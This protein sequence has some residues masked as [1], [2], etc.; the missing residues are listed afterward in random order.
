MDPQPGAQVTPWIS[1]VCLLITSLLWWRMA[2]GWRRIARNW[3]T[4]AKKWEAVAR[5][6]E[7]APSPDP[8]TIRGIMSHFVSKSCEGETCR[9]CGRQA[10]HKVAED[11]PYDYP[12]NHPDPLV[13]AREMAVL[14]RLPDLLRFELTAYVCCEHFWRILGPA[15]ECVS[16]GKIGLDLASDAVAAEFALRKAID[17]LPALVGP[18][19]RGHLLD[20]LERI[21]NQ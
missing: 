12:G 20:L 13:N 7:A 5:R 3:E 1:V 4:T 10:T 15:V 8:T 19:E 18:I 11:L 21:V 9:M 6:L 14:R 16:A 17:N 2:V